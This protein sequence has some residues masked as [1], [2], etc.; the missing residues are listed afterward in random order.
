MALKSLESVIFDIT[1]R[2]GVEIELK[3]TK[4][5]IICITTSGHQ[6]RVRHSSNINSL[7]DQ[8]KEDCKD[9]E[10]L[11]KQA[12]KALDRRLSKIDADIF[13]DNLFE[14]K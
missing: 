6:V 7:I 10:R 1:Q 14:T 3:Y 4:R 11:E 9:L 13:P 5:T 12:Q 2:Y 8:V